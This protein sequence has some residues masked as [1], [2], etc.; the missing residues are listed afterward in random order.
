MFIS[1][2]PILY[3]ILKDHLL[4]LEFERLMVLGIDVLRGAVS[5]EYELKGRAS[6]VWHLK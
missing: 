2:E 1:Q 5:V 4:F 6:W 3:G